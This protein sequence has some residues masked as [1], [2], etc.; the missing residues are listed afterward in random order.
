[1][2]AALAFDLWWLVAAMLVFLMQAGFL[3]LETGLIQE[4]HMPGIAIKNVLMLLA[5]S[6]AFTLVG[7][8]IMWKHASDAWYVQSG[9]WQFY[10]T[11]F[12]AVAATIL[13]GAMAGRTRLTANIVLAIL[14]AGV[15][16]PLH[17]R[18]VWGGGWL[19]Q[20]GVHDF[21]GSGA[22]HVLGGLVALVGAHVVGPR[23]EKL[24]RDAAGSMHI[25][26]SLL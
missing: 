17:G 16:F 21:A 15:L 18:W 6:A 22:V 8:D 11:G 19:E 7:Y 9:A 4:R 23:D 2:N 12:A 10:Q 24:A 20:I 14:V 13:S 25:N 26:P 5:S 3:L 1:M